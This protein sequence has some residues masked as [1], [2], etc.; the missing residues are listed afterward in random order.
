MCMKTIKKLFFKDYSTEK[1]KDEL[2]IQLSAMPN[3]LITGHH[4]FLTEE[5]LTKIVETTIY[6]L[7]CWE[8]NKETENELTTIK[9]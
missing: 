6:N 9:K 5:S 2:F 7:D 4:V 8:E 3:V 1:L